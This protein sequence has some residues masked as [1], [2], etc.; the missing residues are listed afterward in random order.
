MK[1]FRPSL[2]IG[3][4]VVGSVFAATGILQAQPRIESP[5]LAS[6]PAERLVPQVYEEG[7]AAMLARAGS[8][9]VRVIFTLSARMVGGR[10]G[11][12]H[13]EL[14]S[15]PTE[16]L[17]GAQNSLMGS[18][19]ALS[20]EEFKPIV[21]TPL[22]VGVV[23]AQQLRELAAS[24]QI[25]RMEEDKINE[26]HLAQ[27]T[28]L[29]NAPVFW[30]GGIGTRGQGQIVAVL[31][32]GVMAAHNF[33]AGKVVAEACFSTTGTAISGSDTYNTTALCVNGSTSPGAGA[34]CNIV[35]QKCWHGTH[36]A[37]IAVGKQ[38]GGITY[39]GVAPEA[40]VLAIQV[41]S[42]LVRQ[43]DS[44]TF[45]HSFDSDLLSALSLVRARKL[46]GVRIAA[47]NMSLGGG[48]Y[49]AH[50]SGTTGSPSS[51]ETSIQLLHTAG[52]ATVISSGN[53]GFTNAVGFPACTTSAITVGS[54]TKTDVIATTSNSSSMIDA[55]APGA[56]I[57]SATSTGASNYSVSGGTSMAAPHVAG[58]YALL[59]QRY[60]CYP[61]A[62]L[63]S[64]I[65]S[66]GVSV[67]HPSNGQTYKRINLQAANTQLHP[68]RFVHACKLKADSISILP[69]GLE[70]E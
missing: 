9:K 49:M 16:A 64:A 42:K 34:P 17:T 14:F 44:V 32:T 15:L 12:T 68:M 35:G 65:R 39:N 4:I 54:T 29:I 22:V 38:N 23:N 66:T 60:P 67:A 53:D 55:L 5:N 46:A 43:S 57:T 33:L 36:V 6:V 63:D 25:G 45:I 2:I 11:M 3:S 41:F 51:F 21:G 27:S 52:V 28:P 48:N 18:M 1:L 59:R 50:C 70:K 20:I 31:D 47:V 62:L 61:Q 37:G 30:G 58:A 56:A 69:K 10:E 7:L 13:V 8:G 19:K 24:G 40:K 26:P